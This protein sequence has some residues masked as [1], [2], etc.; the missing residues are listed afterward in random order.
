MIPPHDYRGPSAGGCL[1]LVSDGTAK[2]SRIF[3]VNR[4]VKQNLFF[5]DIQQAGRKTGGI[6]T[7]D[8]HI[9]YLLVY[10]LTKIQVKIYTLFR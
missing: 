9:Y 3:S 7:L 6:R 8:Y 2:Q 5:W 1:F 10:H 4:G